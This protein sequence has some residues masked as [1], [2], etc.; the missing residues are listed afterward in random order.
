M[1]QSE[2]NRLVD[3]H[4]TLN[5]KPASVCGRLCDFPHIRDL[6]PE[7]LDVEYCWETVKHFVDNKEGKFIA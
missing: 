1:K 2:K 6:N 3:T 4:V 5:G 7:G